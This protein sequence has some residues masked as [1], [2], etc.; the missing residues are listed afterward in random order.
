MC[1][2][3]IFRQCKQ[4]AVETSE[5][6]IKRLKALAKSCRF[7]DTECFEENL[8]EQLIEGLRDRSVARQL[9]A[10]ADLSLDT[11]LEMCSGTE[12]DVN[13]AEDKQ[14]LKPVGGEKDYIEDTPDDRNIYEENVH[15]QISNTGNQDDSISIPDPELLK[16]GNDNLEDNVQLESTHVTAEEFSQKQEHLENSFIEEEEDI[17]NWDGNDIKEDIENVKAARDKASTFG[18]TKALSNI[19]DPSKVTVEDIQSKISSAFKNDEL[20]PKQ[21]LEIMQNMLN[22]Q[23]NKL[24]RNQTETAA[25]KKQ[26]IV[27]SKPNEKTDADIDTDFEGN[28]NLATSLKGNSCVNEDI[29]ENF[30]LDGDVKYDFEENSNPYVHVPSNVIAINPSSGTFTSRKIEKK[31]YMK[32]VVKNSNGVSESRWFKVSEQTANTYENTW[33]E[34]VTFSKLTNAEDEPTKEDYLKYF[35]FLSEEKKLKGTTLG[36]LSSRL[37]NCHIRKFGANNAWEIFPIISDLIREY[38]KGETKPDGYTKRAFTKE[39]VFRALQLR[40]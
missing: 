13:A 11:A 35:H 38:E 27:E 6:Y 10:A 24:D 29:G 18:D 15:D 4:A 31:V 33:K 37:K 19:R 28:F 16:T 40:E 2:L 22:F 17:H 8:I 23:K 5:D 36:V 1:L 12:E 30:S 7:C 21:L 3:Y 20:S 39:Q 9:L 25:T 34:F 26:A 14:E 32:N